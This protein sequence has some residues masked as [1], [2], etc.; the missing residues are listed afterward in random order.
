MNYRNNFLLKSFS[1]VA[2]L[3]CGYF[4]DAFGLGPGTGTDTPI[5]TGDDPVGGTTGSIVP[6]NPEHQLCP[7]GQY[8]YKCGN[9][10]VGFE[11]LKGMYYV[12]DSVTSSTECGSDDWDTTQ[13]KCTRRTKNYYYIT[14][15]ADN[16]SDDDRSALMQQMRDFFTANNNI[17]IPYCAVDSDNNCTVAATSDI[18]TDRNKILETVCN[19]TN[20]MITCAY[21]PDSANI[22][23]SKVRINAVT[24]KTSEWKFYTI[25]DCYM[26]SFTDS[27]GTFKYVTNTSEQAK[28]CYYTNTNPEA[29]SALSGDSIEQFV[30]GV[31]VN[32]A[33]MTIDLPS[34]GTRNGIIIRT[35]FLQ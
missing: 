28:K 31:T 29:F 19:P 4:G 25:A 3:C 33:V 13:N 20:T 5:D 12:D 34:T 7:Q 23:A 17:S 10:R 32:A 9:Y 21:C 11:W 27:T 14:K 15:T 24:R 18:S 1:I 8:V 6:I 16:M 2:V 22:P 35:P 26:D 30:S